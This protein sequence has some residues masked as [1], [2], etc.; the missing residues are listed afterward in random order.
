MRP[1]IDRV[2]RE[3]RSTDRDID[4]RSPNEGI[5][6]GKPFMMRVMRVWC[7][8]LTAGG[9]GVVTCAWKTVHSAADKT[10]SKSWFVF[11]A[12]LRLPLI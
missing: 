3:G 9:G 1:K 5:W 10:P 4:G 8:P 11:V 2:R 12:A 6:F 7:F